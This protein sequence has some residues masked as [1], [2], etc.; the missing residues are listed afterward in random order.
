MSNDGAGA[1]ENGNV[2]NNGGGDVDQEHGGRETVVGGK[3]WRSG[4]MT[5]D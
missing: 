5:A 3:K 4:S 1:R 2:E